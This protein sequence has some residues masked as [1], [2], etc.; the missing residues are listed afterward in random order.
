MVDWEQNTMKNKLYSKD[1]MCPVRAYPES[2]GEHSFFFMMCKHDVYVWILYIHNKSSQHIE[3]YYFALL[4]SHISGSK[5][6]SLE[7]TLQVIS[8][9]AW[10]KGP[11]AE[12]ESSQGRIYPT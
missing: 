12:V 4:N 7:I 8:S 1:S 9:R 3:F 11:T 10:G 2:K 6:I 5:N